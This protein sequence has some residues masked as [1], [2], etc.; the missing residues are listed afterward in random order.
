MMKFARLPVVAWKSMLIACLGL[1]VGSLALAQTAEGPTPK[2]VDRKKDT[3]QQQRARAIARCRQNRGA[4]CD[5]PEGLKEWIQQERPITD[6][7]RARA[8]GA[9]RARSA[10]KRF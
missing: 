9:R 4:D 2:K 7:E 1:G 6:E 8:A 5:T 3:V 10:P